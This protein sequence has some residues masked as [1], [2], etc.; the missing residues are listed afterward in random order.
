MSE[1]PQAVL[2]HFLRMVVDEHSAVLDPTAGSGSA[3]RAAITSG[4]TRYLGLEINS[5]FANTA[6]ETLKR[7]LEERENEQQPKP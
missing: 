1:K 7:F 4:A 5:E 3:I 6:D 2:N